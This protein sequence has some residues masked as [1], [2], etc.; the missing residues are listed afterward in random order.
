MMRETQIEFCRNL[1]DKLSNHLTVIKGY[2]DLSL[3]KNDKIY[4]N[5][6]RDEIDDTVKSINEFV[7]EINRWHQ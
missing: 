4:F 2:L 7:D 6:L 5:Q 1:C 3:K